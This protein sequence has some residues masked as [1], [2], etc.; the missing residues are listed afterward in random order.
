VQPLHLIHSGYADDNAVKDGD[1]DEQDGNDHGATVATNGRAINRE[2]TQRF[3]CRRESRPS[4]S[5]QFFAS[6][7]SANGWKEFRENRKQ[8]RCCHWIR[9]PNANLHAPMSA[10]EVKAGRRSVP[11]DMPGRRKPEARIFPPFAL[12]RARVC[13][14]AKKLLRK[15]E[16]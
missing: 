9:L 7:K 15:K 8:L 1:E 10:P 14:V 5:A 12:I 13:G 16:E 11:P 2:F 3:S 4:L 6:H